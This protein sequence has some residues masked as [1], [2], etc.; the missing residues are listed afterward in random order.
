MKA[1]QLIT[2]GKDGVLTPVPETL[3]ILRRGGGR[4][5]VALACVAG[6]YVAR[7][8]LA[9]ILVLKSRKSGAYYAFLVLILLENCAFLALK[10]RFWGVK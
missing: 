3:E 4:R 10:I 1:L 8:G 6:A 9:L 7:A 2:A 5:P